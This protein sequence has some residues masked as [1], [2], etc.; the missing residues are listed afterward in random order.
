[1]LV[2]GILIYLVHLKCGHYYVEG[3]GYSTV[4]D[5]LSGGLASLLVLVLLFG[6]KVSESFE[7][8]HHLMGIKQAQLILETLPQCTLSKSSPSPNS[9]S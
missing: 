8:K 7:E 9:H 6:L 4:Q 2:V 3:V 1:M 5:V